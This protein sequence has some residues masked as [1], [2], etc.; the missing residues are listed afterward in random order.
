MS[1]AKGIATFTLAAAGLLGLG[2]GSAQAAP[3]LT[4]KLLGST[5]GP[6]GPFSST[7]N[8][9]AGDVVNYQVQVQLGAEGSANSFAGGATPI[10]N[11]VPSNG[12][13]TPTSGLNSLLFSLTQSAGDSI[14]SDFDTA[15]AGT[16]TGGGTWGAGSGSSPGTVTARGNGNDNLIGVKLFRESGNYD[17]VANDESLELLTIAT[18]VFDIASGGTSGSVKADLTGYTT[19]TIIAFYRWRN[20]QNTGNIP[21]NQTVT[22]QNNSTT[23]GDP[24]IVFQPLTLVPEPASLGLLAAGALGLLARRRRMA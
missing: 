5:T 12:S 14:Q 16:T 23:G 15:A 9:G 17:G 22:Q 1:L 11:W 3:Y 20:A 13:T 6:G 8:V 19:S 21:F 2:A 10:V 18:G 7:L 24:I 4:V